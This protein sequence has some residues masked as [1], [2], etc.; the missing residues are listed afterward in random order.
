VEG[1]GA[2]VVGVGGGTVLHRV[3]AIF[4]RST[5]HIFASCPSRENAKTGRTMEVLRQPLQLNGENMAGS[6][7]MAGGRRREGYRQ[8]RR[9]T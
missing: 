2:A 6:K 4:A 1:G 7:R 3:P 5:L 9:E 8:V